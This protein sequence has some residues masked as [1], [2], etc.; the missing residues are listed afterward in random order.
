MPFVTDELYHQMGFCGEEDSIM[1]QP[2]PQAISEARMQ[3]LG[4]TESVEQLNAAKYDLVRAVRNLRANY[5]LSTSLPLDVVISPASPEAKAFLDLDHDALAELLNA[6]S[7][8]LGEKPAGPAGVAVSA[9]GNAFVPLAGLVDFAA[10]TARLQKQ[11]TEAEKYIATLQK[12]LA[13]KGYVEHAPAAA[14]EADRAHLAET[15]DKLA[16]IREQLA[17]F[18]S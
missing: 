4:A 7:L 3:E 9:I 11:Q 5:Q 12:K 6:K 10:E 14:V 18:N 13:N 17:A 1:L 15:E 8:T 2:W 16:R